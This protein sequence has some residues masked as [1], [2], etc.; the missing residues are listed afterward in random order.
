MVPSPNTGEIIIETDRP[1]MAP[2]DVEG[3]PVKT[4]N[5]N[6]LPPPPG[7]IVLRPGGVIDHTNQMSAETRRKFIEIAASLAQHFPQR[8]DRSRERY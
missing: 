4:K 5:P 2:K 3:I 8:D 6:K 1:D 7:V